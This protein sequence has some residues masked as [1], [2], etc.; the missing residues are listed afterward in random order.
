MYLPEGEAGFGSRKYK[1][2]LLIDSLEALFNLVSLK[3][4]PVPVSPITGRKV[5]FR[6]TSFVLKK[7]Q[8]F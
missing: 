6:L 8:L 4:I 5:S 3:V 1:Y 7:V 2:P